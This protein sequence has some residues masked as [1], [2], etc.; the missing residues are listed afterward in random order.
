MI[1]DSHLR[2][3]RGA[4]VLAA[5]MLLLSGG[6]FTYLAM[7]SRSPSPDRAADAP[8]RA[9]AGKPAVTATPS[10]HAADDMDKTPLPDVVVALTPDAI[11]RA[12]IV[13][14]PVTSAPAAAADLR[15]PGVVAANAYR[16]IAVTPL[17]TGRVTRVSAE[18]GDRVRRG[19]T[20]AQVHSPELADARTRYVS[21]RA[22]LEA[23]DR[24]LLRTQ[25]LVE[26]GAASRQDLERIHA[27]H[28]AQTAAVQSA[29]AQL[30]LLGVP[31]SALDDAGAVH[32]LNATRNVPS[33]IDGVVTE[34]EA[35]TGLNVEPGTK[36]FTVVD[37]STV[38]VLADVYER[39]F[40]R[41]HV[42][43]AA[44]ITAPA[45]SGSPL[46]ST[47]SYIDPQVNAETR[48]AKIRL[49]VPNPRGG[50]RLGMYVDVV[51]TGTASGSA[52]VIPRSA[53]Q[54]VGHT[55]VVYLVN[56]KEAGRFIEREVRLGSSSAEQVE[57]VSGVQQGDT[58]VS[59]GSFFLRA[60]RERLGPSAAP[61]AG[62]VRSRGPSAGP[63]IPGDARSGGNVQTAR[64]LVGERGYQPATL[65][66][67]GGTPARITFVR[68]TDKTCGLEIVFPSL[69]IKRE[70]PLNQP[71]DIEFTPAKSGEIAFVCGMNMLKGVV[72]LKG[73]L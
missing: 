5:I 32:T 43:S 13:T 56:P 29:R 44:T 35:N 38:W 45:L 14:T 36:L 63:A 70:L 20:I 48:T 11:Q 10:A 16:Q 25:K 50:L 53:V 33:P 1:G 59:D 37:L 73:E 54:H 67:R 64:I 71:V 58:I 61:D 47:I 4:A 22:M 57:V 42:G 62:A 60:E 68:T 46:R 27:E 3:P 7:R 9:D 40:A 2:L 8:A 34:R 55:T 52:V 18:L 69:K 66:L 51:V 17:V 72:I 31:S 21:A 26:I 28:T 49:E 12:G 15:L 24:E 23:H 39:D 30:E 19:Q 6:G 65:T 41:V